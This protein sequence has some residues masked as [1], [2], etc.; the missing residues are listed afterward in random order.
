[1]LPM[2]VPEDISVG[3]GEARAG[4]RTLH[5]NLSA[6]FSTTRSSLRISVFICPPCLHYASN[7]CP[8]DVGGQG[9]KKAQVSRS[10]V[11]YKMEILRQR[12]AECI[13]ITPSINWNRR[14]RLTSGTGSVLLDGAALADEFR[15]RARGSLGAAHEASLDGRAGGRGSAG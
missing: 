3:A 6:N 8:S 11:T 13:S 12:S 1:M 14:S 9:G 4:M 7:W 10:W 5:Q 2:L 15:L